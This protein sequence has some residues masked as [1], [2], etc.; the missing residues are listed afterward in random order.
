MLAPKK[1]RGTGGAQGK[2]K[3]VDCC[4]I[5]FLFRFMKMSRMGNNFFNFMYQARGGVYPKH[6]FYPPTGYSL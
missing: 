6:S 2:L 1:S 3:G 4:L 5:N